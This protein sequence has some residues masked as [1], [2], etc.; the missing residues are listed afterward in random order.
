[1][2]RLTPEFS[3]TRAIREYTE[4]HYLPAASRF[5]DRAADDGAIGSSLL[6]WKKDIDRHWSNVRFVSFRIGTHDGQHFFQAEVAPG[7]LTPDNL[8][9]E[10]YADSTH[11]ELAC[12]EVMH[13]S[14]P[15]SD[16]PGTCTYSAQISAARPAGDYTA[17][18]VPYHPNALVPLE[19]SQIVWQ[20]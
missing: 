19:A 3:A 18:I 4:S 2:A 13:P 1:M 11:G 14:G 15:N 20:H 7:S 10:I 8:R 9:V 12:L 5:R 6:Q 16:T 17:R